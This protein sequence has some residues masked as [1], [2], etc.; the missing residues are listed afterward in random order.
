MNRLW[1]KI[2]RESIP[3]YYFLLLLSVY[4]LVSLEWLF[5]VTK[6]SFLST[7]DNQ[8][9]LEAL[10]IVS[11]E[12]LVASTLVFLLTFFVL[13]FTNL[14][15]KRSNY[16]LLIFPAVF[17]VSLTIFLLI[18]NFSN[19]VIG[20][21]ISDSKD[22]IRIGY[23]L[24]F[25]FIFYRVFVKLKAIFNGNSFI[26]NKSF[27][28]STS[29]I[30]AILTTVFSTSGIL[31]TRED[32]K[33]LGMDIETISSDH[34]SRR[35][36]IIF[37]AS[38]GFRSNLLSI[39]GNKHKTSPNLDQFK[40][41]SLVAQNAFTNSER[42][43]GSITS[44]LTGKYP[45]TNKVLFP[46]HVLQGVNAHQHLP[47]LLKRLG[48]STFQ[49]S[50]RYY[51]DA[52][53]LNFVDSFDVT[54]GIQ[55]NSMLI[56]S[57]IQV[58]HARLLS[59]KIL[60]RIEQRIKHIFFI[61]D[62]PDVYAAV[63]PEEGFA[64]VYGR[65]DRDRID[66]AIEFI[67]KNK[68]PFFMHIHLMDSH[69]CIYSPKKKVF[70][71]K[72][73]KKKSQLKTALLKDLVKESD[74]YFGEIIAALQ[75]ADILDNTLIVYNSDHTNNWGFRRSIPLVFIFPKRR[76]SGTIE[77]NT[78]L[79]DVAPTVLEY[80]NIRKPGW[81]DGRSL[82]SET[83]NRYQPIFGITKLEREHFETENDDRLS[84]IVGNGPPNYGLNIMG[85]IV[86]NKWYTHNLKTDSTKSA[87]VR[88][89]KGSC[90][91]SKMP[92]RKKARSIM[93]EHL[94]TRDFGAP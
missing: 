73:F 83:L 48:Y 16:S 75:E 81:M 10:F 39:Y 70:S 57:I 28:L 11:L 63:K 5:F 1:Q 85:L 36:N 58:Q 55:N 74:D 22:I 35:P 21:S 66:S 38:D 78:Q 50:I 19:T 13:A 94:T 62:M 12:L 60:E 18:D 23:A 42:T 9:T 91:I 41:I 44:M 29:A 6:P 90:D 79:L 64:K 24:L 52:N 68:N 4:A 20:Y 53:D 30:I 87:K 71:D 34:K 65:P 82:I 8:K 84:H 43:T 86:C 59:L 15:I 2:K 89:Y 61:E 45:A 51:A 26:V 49:E 27:A 72:A 69:C 56:A 7:L 46:P 92:T 32:E 77:E 40:S 33:A 25:A 31:A 80:L 47:G 14:L 76:H 17:L 88:G 67:A 37:F 3:R 93:L 54:N